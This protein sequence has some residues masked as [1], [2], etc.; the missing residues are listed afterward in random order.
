MNWIVTADPV[1]STPL[2]PSK[3]AAWGVGRNAGSTDGL[4]H[5]NGFIC[6]GGGPAGQAADP[7]KSPPVLFVPSGGAIITGSMDI[8][9]GLSKTFAVGE[10][11]PQFCAWSVWYWFDGATATCGLP[12]N[13][14]KPGVQPASNAT[15]WMYTYS[16]MSRHPGGANFGMCDGSGTFISN[17]IAMN[18]YW[19][20]ATI[21]GRE[22]VDVPPP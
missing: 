8:R 14:K 4:D 3:P 22:L 15:D 7:T 19:G 1:S 20:M 9:D 5:G 11:I 18:V 6:R 10:A 12:L 2:G 17:T 13:Y 16:F 21:D